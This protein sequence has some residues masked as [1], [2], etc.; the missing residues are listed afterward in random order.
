MDLVHHIDYTKENILKL[1]IIRKL[2]ASLQGGHDCCVQKIRKR[3]G[4]IWVDVFELFVNVRRLIRSE[5]KTTGAYIINVLFPIHCPSIS[6]PCPMTRIFHLSLADL[7]LTF[8]LSSKL[9]IDILER[10]WFAI[11]QWSSS[12]ASHMCQQKSRH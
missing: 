10:F 3:L 2:V 1:Y 8:A 6:P 4:R 11:G 7:S 5:S 9:V 12:E